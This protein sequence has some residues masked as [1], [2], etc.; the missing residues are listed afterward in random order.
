[1]KEFQTHIDFYRVY[2]QMHFSKLLTESNWGNKALATKYLTKYWLGE[3]EY[4][5]RWK[6]I[7]DKIFYSNKNLPDLVFR[8]NF[9]ILAYRGGCLFIE[10]D[11][12]QLQKA[13]KELADDYFVI[14]QISQDFT[15]GEPMFRMKF[16]V[17]I[18]WEE[19]TSGNYISAVLL[20]MSYNE[21]FIFSESGNWGRYSANDY[22]YPVDIIGFKPDLAPFFRKQFPY[23]NE[24]HIEVMSNL[25][26]IYQKK[27]NLLNKLF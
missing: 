1:M 19:L 21:Y 12:I 23:Q 9:E 17:N 3:N 4:L 25:P 15:E 22:K 20:E 8:P 2:A 27:L 6:P 7:Q 18:T 11:F 16:P 14:I 13:M 10:E 24:N 26:D 5:N